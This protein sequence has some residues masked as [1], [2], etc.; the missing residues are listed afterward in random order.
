MINLGAGRK[1]GVDIVDGRECSLSRTLKLG[2]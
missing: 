2:A 1:D